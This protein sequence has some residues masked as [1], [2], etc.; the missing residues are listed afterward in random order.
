MNLFLTKEKELVMDV[1]LTSSLGC[2]DHE[3][4]M[5]HLPR[6][7]RKENRIVQMP[8]LREA[9]FALLRGLLVGIS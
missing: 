3:I 8:D 1:K 6:G 7:I 5:S 2:H 9:D 4:A